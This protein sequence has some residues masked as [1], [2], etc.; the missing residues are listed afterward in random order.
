MEKAGLFDGIR[1][2]L[3]HSKVKMRNPVKVDTFDTPRPKKV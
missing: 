1:Q 3:S 2:A